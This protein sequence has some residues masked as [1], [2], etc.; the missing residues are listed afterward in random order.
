MHIRDDRGASQ[1]RARFP[2]VYVPTTVPRTGIKSAW[3]AAMHDSV[4]LETATMVGGRVCRLAR[5]SCALCSCTRT[6]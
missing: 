1:P 5:C 6:G 2:G 4:L 3:P